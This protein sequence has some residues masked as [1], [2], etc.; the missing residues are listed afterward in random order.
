MP[1]IQMQKLV[2]EY[3]DTIKDQYP[4]L[5]YEDFE[6]I[7][8]APFGFILYNLQRFDTPTILIKYLGKLK[9]F[10]E[11]VK[12]QIKT[13]DKQLKF[14]YISEERHI[15]KVEHYTEILNR[16]LEAERIDD[17]IIEIIE[18]EEY[19]DTND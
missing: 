3:Y 1:Q 11:S 13:V 15:E 16:V 4:E 2:K 18:S 5:E 14:G 19:E 17:Q 7:C 6:N 9:V 10:S 8:K 12:K